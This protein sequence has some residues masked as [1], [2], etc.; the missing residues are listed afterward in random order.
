MPTTR[1]MRRAAEP[2]NDTDQP[3]RQQRTAFVPIGTEEVPLDSE[4][5]YCNQ[6][7][8]PY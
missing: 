3:P 7:R 5:L 8:W 6:L 4:E 2:N 1:R